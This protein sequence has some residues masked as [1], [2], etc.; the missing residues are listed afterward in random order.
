MGNQ[1]YESDADKVAQASRLCSERIS[2]GKFAAFVGFAGGTPA[3][4]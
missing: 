2:V 4:L 3:L 1:F